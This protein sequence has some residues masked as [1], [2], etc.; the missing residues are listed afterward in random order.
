MTLRTVHNLADLRATVGRWRRDGERVAFVPTM[1]NLHAGHFRLVARARELGR[2]V[3]V[4]IF[5]N[6]LQFGPGEDYQTYPRTLDADTRGLAE[7]DT[8]LVFAPDVDTMYPG[9]TGVTTRVT[10]PELSDILCG[11]SRPG[12]F[13]GV[14]TVVNRLFN[15]VQ[16]DVAVFGEKDYQQLQIIRRMVRDLAMPVSVE[17]VATER[18][19]DGLALSSR[20]QYLTAAER[21]VAPRLYQALSEAVAQIRD[22]RRDFAALQ[23]ESMA[24]LRS[25]GFQPDYFEV[26]DANSLSLPAPESRLVVL[27][28][29]RLGR[30]RLIDNLRVDGA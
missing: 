25:A 2:R 3:V 1:G 12:H 17:G 21:A 4:S 10:V 16:P 26:R 14:T 20:N 5:V 8:D 30:A 7:R 27:A 9:G 13:D 22:G 11:A 29:A 18:E 6:P 28:A 23:A 15:M 19:A 24:G